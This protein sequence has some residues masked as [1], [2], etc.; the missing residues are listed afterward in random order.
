MATLKQRVHRKNSSG[1][2][3]TIHYETSASCVVTSGGNSAQSHLDNIYNIKHNITDTPNG[4]TTA[5]WITY[6][7][8]RCTSLEQ[9]SGGVSTQ[10]LTT[11]ATL[12]FSRTYNN[13]NVVAVSASQMSSLLSDSVVLLLVNARLDVNITSTPSGKAGLYVFSQESASSFPRDESVNLLHIHSSSD[14]PSTTLTTN[15]VFIRYH[16]NNVGYSPIYFTSPI[17]YS[18]SYIYPNYNL[19]IYSYDQANDMVG[20]ATLYITLK[21]ISF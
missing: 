20:S 9:S 3:D 1:S 8:N 14:L 21:A 15:S 11:T 19:Y 13:N 7:H 2:Y 10:T 17:H 5:N 4:D 6:L 16:L 18:I 12:N